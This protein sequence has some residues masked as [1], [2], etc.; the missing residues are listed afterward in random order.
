MQKAIIF[1]FNRTLYDPQ[2]QLLMPEAL[3]V[4]RLLQ[5]VGY[6]MFLIGLYS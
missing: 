1:D 5:R 2:A 4:L 3:D 6:K